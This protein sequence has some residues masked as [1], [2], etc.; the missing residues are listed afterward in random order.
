ME[1]N[2]RK[3]V[4]A[5]KLPPMPENAKTNVEQIA[6]K[7]FNEIQQDQLDGIHQAEKL[8][9]RLLAPIKKSEYAATKHRH[10]FK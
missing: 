2:K 5:R 4:L 8:R 10:K 9:P 1:D 7:M 6:Q 3:R